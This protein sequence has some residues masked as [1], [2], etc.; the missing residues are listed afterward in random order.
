VGALSR[1]KGRYHELEVVNILKERGHAAAR[2]LDQVRDGGGDIPFGDWLIECKRRKTISIYAW[3]A[4]CLKACGQR[5]PVLVI[6]A[7]NKEN[8]A[9]IRLT[10]F[11]D[12]I[13]GDNG[14][15][16]DA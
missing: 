4:Q 13:R 16:T 7:D 8:L 12:L 2:N 6:R 1:R 11:L 5:K 15:S 3:M 9:V 10:D 14:H